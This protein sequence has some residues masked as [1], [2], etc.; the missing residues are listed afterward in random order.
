MIDRDHGLSV[1]RQAKVLGI[2]RGSVYCL[3][4]PTAEADL[5]LIAGS[6]N[7]TWGIPSQAAGC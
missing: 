1:S 7:C 6:T 4:R 3:P 2:S 5:V